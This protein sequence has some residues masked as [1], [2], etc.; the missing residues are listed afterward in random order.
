MSELIL[1]VGTR[2]GAP[3]DE[4][5][6]LVDGLV[7]DQQVDG[8][9]EGL[10]EGRFDEQVDGP[11]DGDAVV[12][13]DT[14]AAVVTSTRKRTEP[15]VVELAR[16]LGVPL[17]TYD[18]ETLASQQVAAPSEVVR[19]HVGVPSVAEAAVLAAGGA[20]VARARSAT[21]TVV[22]GRLPGAALTP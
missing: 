3:V 9:V 15:A 17:Q 12:P 20:V 6:A 5:V 19:R 2:S 10:D 4:L 13:R 7:E 14:V 22:L 1:G 8:L 18:D 21:A 16:H 11:A